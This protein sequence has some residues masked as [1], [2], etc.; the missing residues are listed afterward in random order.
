M[1]PT[2]DVSS[3]NSIMALLGQV[4]VLCVQSVKQGLS[5]H[6]WGELVLRVRQDERWGA[7]SHSL[8]AVRRSLIQWLMVCEKS[9]NLLTSLLGIIVLN[10]FLKT[11]LVNWC[12]HGLACNHGALW[13]E[14]FFQAGWNC[15]FWW[16]QVKDLCDD[17]TT[18][19]SAPS[20]KTL[21]VC[22]RHLKRTAKDG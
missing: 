20:F 22:R 11:L 7:N 1:N 8:R 17:P 15:G 12:D 13:W 16:G 19:L 4:T 14:S 9:C 10:Q 3:L 21:P 18:T 5:T 2:T 6:P